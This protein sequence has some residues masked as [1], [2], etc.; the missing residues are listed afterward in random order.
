MGEIA[1]SHAAG[2]PQEFRPQEAKDKDAK[3]DA[4]ISYAKKVKDW[5][6]LEAAIDQKIDQQ[7]EFIDWW[8]SNVSVRHRPGAAGINNGSVINSIPADQAEEL[9]GISPMQVSRWRKRLNDLDKYRAQLFGA[10]YRKFW[11]TE[12]SDSQLVQ[13]SLSNE[14]YTPTE[15]VEA[16]RRVLGGI[17]LDPASC[18]EANK[19]VQAA[20]F[21]TVQDDGLRQRWEGSVWLNP[22][23]GGLSGKFIEKLVDEHRAGDVDAAI[24]LVNAHCT[25]TK[26]FQPLWEYVLCFTNHRI[27]FSGDDTRSG[28]THGSVFAYLGDKPELFKQEFSAFGAVVVKL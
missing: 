7:R 10:A 6:T 26:W 13:Q 17:D 14:H 12:Q 20:Q 16:A 9:T 8:Q 23:Y 24:A 2:L 1:K 19:V 15:Y 22:P 25:D 11:G 4:V 5:P 28:S 3:L 27:D 18:K 21:F